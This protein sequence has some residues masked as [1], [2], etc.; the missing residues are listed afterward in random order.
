MLCELMRGETDK[1]YPHRNV[2]EHEGLHLWIERGNS[3]Y[4]KCNL[5]LSGYTN[6][7]TKGNLFIVKQ[8]TWNQVIIQ[9]FV[10][11]CVPDKQ[12]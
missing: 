10:L 9:G 12:L 2:E 8:I 11:N 6:L 7:M 4:L 1:A 3:N 5:N